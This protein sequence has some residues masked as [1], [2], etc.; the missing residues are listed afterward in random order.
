[1]PAGGTEEYK[2][3]FVYQTDRQTD[4]HTNFSA[5]VPNEVVQDAVFLQ[6]QIPILVDG[7]DVMLRKIDKGRMS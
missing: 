3:N 7:V 1:M 6:A 5:L 2:L 4:I